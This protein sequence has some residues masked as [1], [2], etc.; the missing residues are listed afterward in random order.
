MKA[1]TAAYV[2]RKQKKRLYRR[3]WITRLNGALS[4]P[5]V[6]PPTRYASFQNRCDRAHVRLNRKTLSQLCL[7]DDHGFTTYVANLH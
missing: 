5:H 3:L 2:G 6:D 4:R 1:R 7:A